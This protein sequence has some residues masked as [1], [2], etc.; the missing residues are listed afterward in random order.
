MDLLVVPRDEVFDLLDSC[1]KLCLC[2]GF[3][4]DFGVS[5]GFGFRLRLK[6]VESFVRDVCERGEVVCVPRGGV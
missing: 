6:D 4:I 2:G 5:R 1:V 3:Q